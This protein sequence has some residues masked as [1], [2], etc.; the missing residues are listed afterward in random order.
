MTPSDMARR[1]KEAVVS[2][3][4]RLTVFDNRKMEKLGMTALM[5]VARGSAEPAKFIILEYSGAQKAEKPYVIV[6]KGITFDSGGISL[7]PAEG[8]RR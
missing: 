5:S 1:A 4:V 2:R 3:K 7:K 6:G 8:W